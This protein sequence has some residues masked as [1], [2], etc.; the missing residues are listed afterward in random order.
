MY[1]IIGSGPKG[2]EV[3]CTLMTVHEAEDEVRKWQQEPVQ[4]GFEEPF[5]ILTVVPVH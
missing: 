3:I 2:E 4:D 1:A 5:D